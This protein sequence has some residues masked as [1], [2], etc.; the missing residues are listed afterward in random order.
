MR[1]SVV[2]VTVCTQ[3][4]ELI[5]TD[6]DNQLSLILLEAILITPSR[7]AGSPPV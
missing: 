2:V 7:P 5:E 1:I 4:E 6:D 3:Y